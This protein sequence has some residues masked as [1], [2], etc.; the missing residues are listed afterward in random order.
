MEEALRLRRPDLMRHTDLQKLHLNTGDDHG[1]CPSEHGLDWLLWSLLLHLQTPEYGR[2]RLG[3]YTIDAD[4]VGFD[5]D[6]VVLQRKNKE[7]GSCPIDKL[8]KEDREYLKSKE[9]LE[10]HT[11]N[12]D[13][14]QTWVMSNGLKVVGKSP[15]M[16]GTRSSFSSGMEKSLS[17]TSHLMICPSFIRIF[18]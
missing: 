13:Q 18:C 2:M 15:T 5:D 12:L 9:A 10:I 16:S 4:L 7:L 11:R 3:I 1:V 17:M 14:T 6:M 8:C